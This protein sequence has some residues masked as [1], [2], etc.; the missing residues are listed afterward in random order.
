MRWTWICLTVCAWTAAAPGA[1]ERQPESARMVAMGGAGVAVPGNAWGALANPASLA[2]LAGASGGIAIAP[3]PFGL[4]ELSRSA[5][6]LAAPWRR[7][8][9]SIGLLRSGYDLYRETTVGAALGCD[10]GMGVCLGGACTLNVLSIEGYG[11]GSCWGCDAGFLWT[12]APG[13]T[14]GACATGINAPRPGRS[15]EEIPRTASAG[16]ALSGGSPLTLAFD[17]ALDPR[18]PPELR[19]GGEYCVAGC[20]ALRAGVSSDPS[21][22]S[23]GVGLALAPLDVE[24]AFSRHQ[25]LGCT[26]RFGIALHLSG[27]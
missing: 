15:G 26:H 7:W 25:E 12:P 21:S 5:L 2:G 13:I 18:F 27:P 14:M 9:A 8:G 17:V 19:L 3:S 20:V 16:V 6:V 10:A 11:S 24:Y 4:T 22:L 23:A 1:F